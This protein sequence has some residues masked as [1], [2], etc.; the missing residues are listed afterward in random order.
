MLPIIICLAVT[1]FLL[2]VAD[3]LWRTKILKGEN[4]RKFTHITVGCFVAAWPWI[5]GWRAIQLIGLAMALVVFINREPQFL[6]LRGIMKS[7][8]ETYGDFCFALGVVACALITNNKAF[9]ALAMLNM[10]L[11]DGLA[12]I[13][14]K[15]WGSHWEYKV[16]HHNKTIIGSMTFWFVSLCIFAPGLLFLNNSIAFAQ[17]AGLL[18][19][20]PPTL[21]M[22]ENIVGLGLDNLFIPVAV[23]I[24]LQLLPAV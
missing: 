10:A 6:H 11:A 23:I 15:A 4:Q 24:V 16:F 13:V 3:L 21:M 14:G 12:A 9:F 22:I 17:Y 7:E 18:I 19:F 20:L 2:I 5:I 8:R 1:F